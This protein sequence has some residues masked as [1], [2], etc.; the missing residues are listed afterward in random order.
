MVLMLTVSRGCEEAGKVRAEFERP[1][2]APQLKC[3]AAREDA[4]RAGV[5]YAEHELDSA[6]RHYE[7]GLSTSSFVTR[8]R[9][10]LL[11]AHVHLL[12]AT[13]DC[14]SS[15]VAFESLQL[16]PATARR[17]SVGVCGATVQLIRTPNPKRMLRAGAGGFQP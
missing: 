13:L 2:A 9:R 5:A 7:V 1:R 17:K 3:A 15:L 4:E 6:Q 16:A 8:T 12:Q 11:Q 10:D 14:Q